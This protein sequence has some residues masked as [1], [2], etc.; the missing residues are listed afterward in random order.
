[1]FLLPAFPYPQRPVPPIWP[2]R[3]RR[4]VIERLD[5]SI[6]VERL[7]LRYWG[8]DLKPLIRRLAPHLRQIIEVQGETRRETSVFAPGMLKEASRAPEPVEAEQD[9]PVRNSEPPVVPQRSDKP[10]AKAPVKRR[11]PSAQKTKGPKLPP[12]AKPV[13]AAE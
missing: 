3:A 2:V 9:T 12:K 13:Q 10:K 1:M 6:E 8:G 4:H 5:C 7:P 11:S